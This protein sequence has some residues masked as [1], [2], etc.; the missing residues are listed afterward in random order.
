MSFSFSFDG[1]P[2]DLR[3]LA[4][5]LQELSLE[6]ERAINENDSLKLVE[7]HVVPEKLESGRLY[8]ADGADWDPG[9]GRGVYCYDS[10]GPTWRLLG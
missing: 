1:N 3:V 4:Q 10:S 8:F 5:R 7:L 6:I 9:S 2:K